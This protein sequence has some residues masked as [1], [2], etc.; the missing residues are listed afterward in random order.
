[1]SSVGV[2]RDYSGVPTAELAALYNERTDCDLR[3]FAAR[4]EM[5]ERDL[6]KVVV[7][8]H[9]P[10]TGLF[11]ADKIVTGLGENIS[12]LIGDG[13]LHLIPA[14]GSRNAA[15]R[16]VE[17]S[18]LT[19]ND[20]VCVVHEIDSIEGLEALGIGVPSDEEIEKRIAKLL[21]LRGELAIK[22]PEQEE[23]LRRDAERSS[24][25]LARKREETRD[26][27]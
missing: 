27:A 23:R 15:R 20:E 26:T 12:A 5:D 1:M 3:T 10:F 6:K 2:E 9:Y 21:A 8:Q 24:V 22:S 17:E 14:R 13:E 7:S 18:I 4:I 11:V 16:I 19:E 25:R